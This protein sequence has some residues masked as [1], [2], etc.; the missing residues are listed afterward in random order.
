MLRLRVFSR[1]TLDERE[2]KS[3]ILVSGHKQMISMAISDGIY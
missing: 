2:K 1:S 3:T